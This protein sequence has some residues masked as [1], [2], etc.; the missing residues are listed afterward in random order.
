MPQ[1]GAPPHSIISWFCGTP[2]HRFLISF[3]TEVSVPTQSGLHDD[4]DT[5]HS[6]MSGLTMDVRHPHMIGP[7]WETTNDHITRW[8]AAPPIW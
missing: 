3:R 4:K 6:V 1:K 8:L 5:E 7:S 2:A